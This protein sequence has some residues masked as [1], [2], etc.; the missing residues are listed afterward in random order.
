MPKVYDPQFVPTVGVIE[1]AVSDRKSID[2]HF[3]FSLTSWARCKMYVNAQ[4]FYLTSMKRYFQKLFHVPVSLGTCQSTGWYIVIC[5]L[6]QLAKL[7]DVHNFH[8]LEL[9]V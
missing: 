3:H 9:A 5:Y 6:L 1:P 8:Y 2:V 7:P 4:A